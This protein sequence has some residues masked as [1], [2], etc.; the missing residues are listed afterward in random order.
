[1]SIPGK[2][3]HR[4][5]DSQGNTHLPVVSAVIYGNIMLPI[6]ASLDSYLFNY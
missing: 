5:T 3:E 1:M 2:I 4:Q 6:S